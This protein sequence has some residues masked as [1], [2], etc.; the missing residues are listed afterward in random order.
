ML[1]SQFFICSLSDF[2]NLF[3]FLGLG[4]ISKFMIENIQP[5]I[6]IRWQ[7]YL[8]IFKRVHFYVFVYNF[9]VDSDLF[10]PSS[11]DLCKFFNHIFHL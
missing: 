1:L 6:S 3:L 11:T 5:V 10:K 4:D 2:K 9:V 8:W 7:C